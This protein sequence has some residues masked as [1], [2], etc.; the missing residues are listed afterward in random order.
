MECFKS[1]R[2]WE[3]EQKARIIQA[4][5]PSSNFGGS[6]LEADDGDVHV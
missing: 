3:V 4:T 1:C 2:L 5:S 6:N